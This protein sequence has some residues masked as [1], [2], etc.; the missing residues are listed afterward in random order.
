MPDDLPNYELYAIRYATREGR[1]ADNFIGGDPHDGPMRMDYFM[2]VAIG[3]ERSFI[4]DSGFTAEMAIKRKREYLRCPVDALSL[5]GLSA[6]NAH[7]VVLTHLHYDH[8]GN[9]AKF[10]VAQFHLQE[11]EIHFATGR[12]MRHHCINHSFEVDDVVGIVRL[13]YG[14]RVTFYRGNEELAPGITLH[15]AGGHSGG[16][17]FLRIH[18][19]R[20]WVVLASDVLHFFENMDSD[21]PF[22]TVFNIGDAA[23]AFDLVRKQAPSRDHIIPGHD[24]LVMDMYPPPR[25]DLAGIIVRLDVPPIKR[26]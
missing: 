21:R 1:R 3:P 4:I 25:P 23:E 8:V 5:L 14:G 13:N 16:L 6:E 2:W 11:P 19:Q 26:G 15:L 9:F 10:P 12:Y 18:T 20:G 7:D 24:P 22:T 17:Q